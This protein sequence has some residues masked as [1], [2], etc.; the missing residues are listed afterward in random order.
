MNSIQSRRQAAF[1]IR[2]A[3]RQ[4][5]SPRLT[6]HDPLF[7]LR[8][9]AKN[10]ILVEDHLSHAHKICPDC[11]R[12]H[13]LCIEGLAEEA[14]C[15]DTA[16][17]ISEGAERLAEYARGWLEDFTDGVEPFSLACKIRDVRKAIVP[18]SFDPRGMKERVASIHLAR[19]T[20]CPHH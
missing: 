7:N 2:V 19:Q 15:L 18:L 4:A 9:I 17:L 3:A 11:I 5:D 14:T 10:L 12:K 1:A 13:L 6:V 8:E 16:G 20:A